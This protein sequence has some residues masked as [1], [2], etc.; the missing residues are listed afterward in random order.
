MNIDWG[1]FIRK[2]AAGTLRKS[3]TVQAAFFDLEV[4][5][6]QERTG[7]AKTG[8]FVAPWK[9][10][11]NRLLGEGAWT[12]ADIDTAKV[13][14]GLEGDLQDWQNKQRT[15]ASL[16]GGGD[17]QLSDAEARAIGTK[18]HA[19]FKTHGA[20]EYSLDALSAFYHIDHGVPF[21]DAKTDIRAVAKKNP[22]IFSIGRGPAPAVRRLQTPKGS[23][24]GQSAFE[25]KEKGSSPNVGAGNDK[26]LERYMQARFAPLGIT[27]QQF[28][29][30]K[31]S[32]GGRAVTV[33]EVQEFLGHR[34]EVVRDIKPGMAKLP[35]LKA[36]PVLDEEE[37]DFP[38]AEEDEEE[39]DEEEAPVQT[40]KMQIKGRNGIQ[41][42]LPSVRK[43]ASSKK[44][45]VEEDE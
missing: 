9:S 7:M 26:P 15:L 23:P 35:T 19:T 40:T 5:L 18:L 25:Y 42:P 2:T 14:D 4:Y 30:A 28:E 32:F 1:L 3:A 44:V 41:Q 13:I 21:A 36:A 31:K 29:A 11:L 12:F 37:E 34:E 27:K 16:I 22:A 6:Q 8:E 39:E 38:E 20:H 45:F 10:I 43:P 17:K 33:A 24:T